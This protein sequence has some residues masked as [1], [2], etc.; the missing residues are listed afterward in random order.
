MLKKA[1]YWFR[2]HFRYEIEEV[3]GKDL[4]VYHFWIFLG[5]GIFPFEA[6]KVAIVLIVT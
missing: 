4:A 3:Y 5:M 6:K 2:C 1:C